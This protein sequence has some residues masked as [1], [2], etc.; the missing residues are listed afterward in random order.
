M[1]FS[2]NFEN[3]VDFANKYLSIF[4]S[5][6]AN[7]LA[8]QNLKLRSILSLKKFVDNSCS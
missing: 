6:F 2:K 5:F 1:L 4:F 3:I 7:L 8:K